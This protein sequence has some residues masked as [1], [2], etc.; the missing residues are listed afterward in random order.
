MGTSGTNEAERQRWN[1]ELWATMW[2]RRE[3]LTDRVTPFL[4]G[5]LALQAA[6]HVLDIGCGGGKAGLA[7][8]AAVGTDGAVV[9]IDISEPLL[10]LAERRAVESKAAN[11]SFV[12]GDAQEDPIGGGEFDVAMSQFGVMFFDDP[13]AAF[14]NVRA[15][16]RSGGRI[17]FACWQ[18]VDRNPWFPGPVLAPFVTPPPPP[19]PGKSPTGPFSL[20]DPDRVDAILTESGFAD[21]SHRTDEL[22][23]EAPG[24]AIV[25]D[26]QLAF[27]GVPAAAMDDARAAVDQHLSQFGDPVGACEFPLAFQIVTA[28]RA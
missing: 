20:C 25:D 7:A 4:L 23:V 21:V 14:A 8:A 9:G 2:P 22:V 1:D 6:E 18:A 13:V 10:A 26:A 3:R 11:V 24:D 17:G 28:R 12:H 5:A 19:A 15:H 27:L 16:L